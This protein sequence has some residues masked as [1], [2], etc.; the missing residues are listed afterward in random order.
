MPPAALEGMKVK[1][2]GPASALLT[3]G[4]RVRA[5]V[6]CALCTRTV[7]AEVAVEANVVYR[8]AS[9]RVVPGQKCPRC[10]S[11]LDAAYVVG[12]NN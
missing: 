11:Y 3:T 6:Y 5:K 1:S 9:L 7:N 4:T 8:K 12:P 2:P 10:S